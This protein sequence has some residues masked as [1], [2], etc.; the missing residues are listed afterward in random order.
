VFFPSHLQVLWTL[1]LQ[2]LADVDDVHAELILVGDGAVLISRI[3]RKEISQV[4]NR[5][6]R[7]ESA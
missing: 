5:L 7:R 1:R 4:G 6:L 2:L 3:P